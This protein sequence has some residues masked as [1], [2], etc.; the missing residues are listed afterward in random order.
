M[1]NL[2]VHIICHQLRLVKLFLAGGLLLFAVQS[3]A[4]TNAIDSSQS[5]QFWLDKLSHSHR[6]LN[7]TGTL[8]F[9]QGERM[10]SLSIAHAVIDGQEYERLDYLDGDKRRVVRR[11]H[12]LNCIHA[13]HHLLRFY[14]EKTE[15]AK[16]ENAAAA[17]RLS[18]NSYYTFAVLNDSRVAGREAI[19]L[20][21][22]PKDEHRFAYRLTLDK[23]TGLM[24]RSELIGAN[25]RV[26]ERFQYVDIN[27]GN[28]KP[29]SYFANSEHGYSSKHHRVSLGE[30]TGD[31]PDWTVGW[32]P[33]GFTATNK[34][35]AVAGDMLTYTDGLTVF[36]VFLELELKDGSLAEGQE[37][38]AQ[39]GATT[40]YSRGLLLEGRAH[41]VT[42]VGE[43]PA[44]TAQLIAKSVVLAAH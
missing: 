20:T 3:A 17:E 28:A 9:Q 13:G 2:F 40:A 21:V 37:Q 11:G 36:S 8:S 5:A 26:L 6:E 12:K 34:S 29:L 27:I 16:D 1:K 30:T 25:E 7:Y 24:L 15:S 43:I 41:R 39:R 35:G 14:S 38:R 18:L 10:E 44:I 33:E 4:V 32:L 42:V 22:T 19:E 23:A 31:V